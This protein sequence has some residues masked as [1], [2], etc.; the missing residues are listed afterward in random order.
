MTAVIAPSV[1]YAFDGPGTLGAGDDG[2]VLAWDQASGKFQMITPSAG[3]TDHGALTGLSD[4]DHA[5]YLLVDG[6]RAMTGSLRIPDGSAGAPAMAFSS[7]TSTGLSLSS[8]SLRFDQSASVLTIWNTSLMRFYRRTQFDNTLTV[9]AGNL[10]VSAGQSTFNPTN[11]STVPVVVKGATSQTSDLQ[12]WQNSA[13]TVLAGIT[14]AGA[15]KLHETGCTLVYNAGTGN[16]TVT[17]GTGVIVE[18]LFA[19]G[20]LVVA[21]GQGTGTNGVTLRAG[22]SSGPVGLQVGISAGAARVGFFGTTPV[23]QQAGIDDADGTLADATTKLN[24][25][26]AALE[27]YGLLAVA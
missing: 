27:A 25:I 16:L 19:N 9:A 11:A 24:A 1:Q 12:Q 26:I 15:L 22:G 10:V 3:V 23:A 18:N 20:E 6:S 13:G 14:A 8:G 4:D 7:A 21:G 17:T 5:Q 2:K